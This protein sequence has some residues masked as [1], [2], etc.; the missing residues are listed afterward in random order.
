LCSKSLRI[1]YCSG[2]SNGNLERGIKTA[3]TRTVSKTPKPAGDYTAQGD[4]RF[5]FCN[6][7]VVSSLSEL[8]GVLRNIDDGT[9]DYHV[10]R[11]KNDISAWV[12]DVFLRSDIS[13]KISKAK[14][15]ASMADVIEKAL[16]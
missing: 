10:N 11:L 3:K 1:N 2:G 13:R 9:Y 6:G 4:Q 12:N 15:R 16:R 7:Q 8:P 14:D 5:Y